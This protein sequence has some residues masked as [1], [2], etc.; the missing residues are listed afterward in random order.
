MYRRSRVGDRRKTRSPKH[1]EENQ[2]VTVE[3]YATAGGFVDER[4]LRIA[5]CI[6]IFVA[7]VRLVFQFVNGGLDRISIW[8]AAFNLTRKMRVQEGQTGQKES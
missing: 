5:D 1:L 6:I 7:P 2:T 3:S 4:A 8:H